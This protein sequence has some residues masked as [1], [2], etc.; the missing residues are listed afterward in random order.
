[1]STHPICFCTEIRKIFVWIPLLS[2]AMNKNEDTD[3][4]VIHCGAILHCFS[5]YITKRMLQ[6]SPTRLNRTLP[7]KTLT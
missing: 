3:Q 2:E 5:V 7:L 6:D 4:P 1:M